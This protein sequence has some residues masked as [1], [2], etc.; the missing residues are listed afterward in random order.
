MTEKILK[1]PLTWKLVELAI[2]A[3]IAFGVFQQSIKELQSDVL[4]LKSH[5]EI[6]AINNSILKT[7]VIWMKDSL[8]RI[9]D[10]LDNFKNDN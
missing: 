8:K 4:T 5:D 1:N 2:I 6:N 10:K 3:S 7:D 9:E